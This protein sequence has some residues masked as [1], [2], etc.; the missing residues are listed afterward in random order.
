MRFSKEVIFNQPLRRVA[1][2]L[3]D[4]DHIRHWQ[5][6]LVSITRDSGTP[7]SA[8]AKSTLSYNSKGRAF[9]LHETLVAAE[10]PAQTVSSYEAP[11]MVHTITN[12]LAEVDEHS[13]KLISDNEI[14]FTGPMRAM[15]PL[16]GAT[17]RRQSEQRLEHLKAY[18]D[19]GRD[20]TDQI[21]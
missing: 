7:G 9:E 2:L 13:T 16:L 19:T 3:G 12:Q 15:G 14:T 1:E 6:D 18:V 5:A 10:L 17:L 8:G 11:G 21:D 4:P 20:V